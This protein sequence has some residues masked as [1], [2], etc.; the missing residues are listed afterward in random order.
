[1]ELFKT[2]LSKKAEIPVGVITHIYSLLEDERNIAKYI[3]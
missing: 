3:Q 1:M 2:I